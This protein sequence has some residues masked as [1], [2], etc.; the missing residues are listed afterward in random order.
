MIFVPIQSLTYKTMRNEGTNQRAE[1]TICNKIHQFLLEVSV[2]NDVESTI[3]YDAKARYRTG[4][5][6]IY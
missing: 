1:G 5:M 3:E 2:R 4:S 6:S